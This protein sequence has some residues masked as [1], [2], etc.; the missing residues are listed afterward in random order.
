MAVKPFNKK[1]GNRIR[2]A[3][4]EAKLTQEE[5]A[6]H[7]GLTRVSIVNM[8]GGR[9]A[10]SIQKLVAISRITGYS[11]AS[12]IDDKG[13]TI[14]ELAKVRHPVELILKLNKISE[15]NL[16]AFVQF[17]NTISKPD[18]NG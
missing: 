8:E 12:M 5:L 18:T 15:R 7:I 10:C 14:P 3:R 13:D 6:E 9:Q 17:N 2:R 11:V 1:V 4:V 16:R